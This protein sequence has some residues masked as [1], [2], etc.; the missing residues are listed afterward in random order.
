[1]VALLLIFATEYGH[2]LRY[3]EAFLLSFPVTRG[4]QPKRASDAVLTAENKHHERNYIIFLELFYLKTEVA[5]NCNQAW[6][7]QIELMTTE[8]YINK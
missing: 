7:F 6:G 8:C 3:K 2:L 5:M 4:G 1:M